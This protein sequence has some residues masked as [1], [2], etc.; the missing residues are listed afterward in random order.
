[1][2]PNTSRSSA[3]SP[4]NATARG[5]K[6][7]PVP[8][9]APRWAR[10]V[11]GPPRRHARAMRLEH[12]ERLTID[13]RPHVRRKPCGISHAQLVHITRQELHDSRR[14]LLLQY[15]NAQRGATL[16]RAIE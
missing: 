16:A 5:A 7:L 10:W 13:D 3:E 15:E 1:M 4:G 9:F 8:A 11:R 6:N 12:R 14:N 2:G